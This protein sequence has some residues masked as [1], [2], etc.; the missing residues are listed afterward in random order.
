MAEKGEGKKGRR[1]GGLCKKRVV[2]RVQ[3]VQRMADRRETNMQIFVKT[4]TEKTI[5]LNV[6]SLD[7][8]ESVK[9]KIQDKE[10]IPLDQQRLIYAGKLLEDDQSLSDYNVADEARLHVVPRPR[11]TEI[12]NSSHP[13]VCDQEHDQEH[14]QEA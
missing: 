13:A 11:K 6:K 12:Q 14:D 10:G 8:I 4:C 1:E 5:T 9:I 3:R 2:Q 7:T